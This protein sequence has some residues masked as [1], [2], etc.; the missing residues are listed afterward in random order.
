MPRVCARF[1]LRGSIGQSVTFYTSEPKN[2]GYRPVCMDNGE[3]YRQ[4]L[5]QRNERQGTGVL[6]AD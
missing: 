3:R 2:V 4:I 5:Q 6:Q 1:C